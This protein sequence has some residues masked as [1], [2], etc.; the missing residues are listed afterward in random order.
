MAAPSYDHDLTDVTLAETTT[1]W[2]RYGVAGNPGVGADFSQQGT[3]CVDKQ[4]SNGDGGVYFNNG[5]GITLGAGDHVWVWHFAATP[6]ITQTI[7]NKG[8]SIYL[9]TATNAVC[10]YHIAGSDTFGASGRVARCY[11]IDY[12][13]RT[14]NTSAPY[15]TT[16]G[17]PGA[18][19]SLFGGGLV[20]TATARTN[21]GVD[22]IRYGTGG[23]LTAGELISAGDA[24]DNPCT[25][26]GFQ[27]INDTVANRFGILTL[28]GGQYELQG[29]F[30]IG[31]NNAGTATLCRFQDSNKTIVVPDTIHAASTFNQIVIDHASTVCNWTNI[32]MNALGTTAPGLLTV[33]A[34]N[35][36]VNITGGTFTSIGAITFRSN[37]TVDG[38]TFRGCQAIAANGCALTNS[39]VADANVATNASAVVWNTAD[40]TDGL[41]DGTSFVKGAASAHGLELGLTSPTTITLRDV[42]FSG[43]NASN[44]QNDS[45]IHVKR[46][47]GTVTIN[48]VGGTSPS[49]R[50]DGATVSIVAN[51]V[52]TTITVIDAITKS[53]LSGA[54]V[55]LQAAAGGPLTEGDTII[56]GTTNGSGQ[57]SDTRTWASNQP[58]TGRARLSTTPGSLYKTG[59]IVGTISSASGLAIT[60]QLI[61]DE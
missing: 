1:G 32:N 3:F 4:V 11:P 34:N 6:G 37:T 57:I 10:E 9:G 21:L 43:Y 46:T 50:T 5:S 55:L 52:T 41:L 45:A 61:P 59:D 53:A 23:Y 48:I 27:S 12:T 58:V 56:S 8:A 51:P 54:R 13:L 17:S 7:Q 40:D 24:S 49:Y 36:T 30:A 38:A 28:V 42:T 31:Q 44:N 18:A 39:L 33:T 16:T 19:P 26:A 20:T 22:A 2:S 29:T 14:N 60:V 35:P 25:F 47:T 15:R